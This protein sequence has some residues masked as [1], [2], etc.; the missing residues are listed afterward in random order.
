MIAKDDDSYNLGDWVQRNKIL[1]ISKDIH[2][3]LSGL[4]LLC[5]RFLV[6]E[7]T[8]GHNLIHVSIN[9][10]YKINAKGATIVISHK[11]HQN[12]DFPRDLKG[13]GGSL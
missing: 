10:V 3:F 1:R 11:C 5:M 12:K 2:L 9:I 4:A 7:K 8:L 6:M 13:G